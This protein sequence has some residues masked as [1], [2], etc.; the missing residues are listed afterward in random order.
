MAEACL[1]PA[2]NAIDQVHTSSNHECCR[3]LSKL[4]MRPHALYCRR[5]CC[6]A[7]CITSDCSPCCRDAL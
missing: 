7:G 5:F 6:L 4:T 3:L 2:S 1:F